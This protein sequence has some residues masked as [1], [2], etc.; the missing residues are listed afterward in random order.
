MS[1]YG[2]VFSMCCIRFACR[3]NLVFLMSDC[4][5]SSEDLAA[6][7]SHYAQLPSTQLKGR[8]RD[9][10]DTFLSDDLSAQ[11][12]KCSMV[13]HWV[14][15]APSQGKTQVAAGCCGCSVEGD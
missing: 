7:F 14:D 11:L 1:L 4:P 3:D 5:H 12:K 6:F 15:T 9:T 13:L 8:G 2:I 10:K